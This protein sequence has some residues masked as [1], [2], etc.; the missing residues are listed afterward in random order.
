MKFAKIVLLLMF[1]VIL[2]SCVTKE[3]EVNKRL[4]DIWVVTQIDKKAIDK[5][6]KIP[7]LEINLKQKLF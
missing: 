3:K 4:H 7:S 6:A 2:Q 1:V 5:T